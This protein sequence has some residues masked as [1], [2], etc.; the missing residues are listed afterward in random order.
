[1]AY[2]V[3]KRERVR[4][5]TASGLMTDNVTLLAPRKISKNREIKS[6][7]NPYFHATTKIRTTMMLRHTCMFLVLAVSLKLAFSLSQQSQKQVN[8]PKQE[9][10]RVVVVGGGLSGLVV[11]HVL[12]HQ[13]QYDVQVLEASP[14]VGGNIKSI[15][16]PHDPSSLLNIGHATHMGFFWN[17]RRLLRHLNVPEYPVGRGVASRTPGLFGMTSVTNSGSL[18]RP[19]LK[20]IIS[21]KIWWEAFWF[22]F[23]SYQDPKVSLQ[24]FLQ[25]HSFSDEFLNIIFWSMATFEFDKTVDEMEEY[26]VGVARALVITQVFFQFLLNDFFAGV[27]PGKMQQGLLDD[28]VQRVTRHQ[29]LSSELDNLMRMDLGSAPL[30]SYF[31]SNYTLAMERLSQDC[32]QVRRNCTVTKVL[33]YPEKGGGLMVETMHG[34]NIQ[35]DA[36]VFTIQP[37]MI[38]KILCKDFVKH[39]AA[40]QKMKSGAVGVRIIHAQDLPF[41]YPPVNKTE[42]SPTYTDGSKQPPPTV[43]GIFDISE[44]SFPSNTECKQNSRTREAGWLSVAFPVYQSE[45]Q[46]RHQKW[47]RDIPCADESVYPWVRAVPPFATARKE[48]V[49]LQGHRGVFITGHALTGVNKAS[50]LQVTNALNLCY[51]YFNAAPPWGEHFFPVPLLPDCNDEDAFRQVTCSLEAAQLALKNLVGSFLLVGVAAKIGVEALD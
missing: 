51:D 11:G 24:E 15:P 43:L 21:Y 8:I 3:T 45:E 12:H 38:Q 48:L 31:T 34:E 1:M 4:F 23:Y 32:G 13:Q 25:K 28:L 26:S 42:S 37:S 29:C 10:I 16:D 18:F 49:K 35:A 14:H 27:L 47:L 9:R 17:L 6:K 5:A 19:T 36:I 50:E 33:R 44:L 39:Q 41:I 7:N 2:R 40:L 22:Y 20:D 30:S 46:N